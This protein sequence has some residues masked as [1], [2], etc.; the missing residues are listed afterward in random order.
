MDL[1]LIYL[2]RYG[3]AESIL[4]DLAPKTILD[5]SEPS[6]FLLEDTLVRCEDEGT[7]YTVAIQTDSQTVF[8]KEKPGFPFDRR[9]LKVLG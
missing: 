8:V 6:T 1:H 3:Q 9:R 7:T 5:P 4:D 2:I